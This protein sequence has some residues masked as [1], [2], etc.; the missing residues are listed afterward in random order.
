MKGLSKVV[1]LFTAFVMILQVSSVQASEV[2][3]VDST[4]HQAIIYNMITGEVIDKVDVTRIDESKG[5]VEVEFSNDKLGVV[6]AEYSGEMKKDG[7]TITIYE[8]ENK[9][10]LTKVYTT[11]SVVSGSVESTQATLEDTIGVS[12][13]SY[14]FVIMKSDGEKVSLTT[15]D[16]FKNILDDKE[17][18]AILSENMLKVADYYSEKGLP[19]ST[20]STSKSVDLV[21]IYDYH[22]ESTIIG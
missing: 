21:L 6:S 15:E 20:K 1:A 16:T 13:D 17:V 11:D 8:T 18:A 10:T 19:L 2:K 9:S 5:M 7:V 14:A 3:V 22:P 12:F 4:N